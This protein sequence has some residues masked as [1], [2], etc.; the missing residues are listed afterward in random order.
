MSIVFLL[1]CGHWTPREI[2]VWARNWWSTILRAR[3]FLNRSRTVL[4][5]VSNW[6]VFLL[7]KCVS[8][9]RPIKSQMHF[10]Y[11]HM[12]AAVTS[13]GNLQ[14]LIG[15]GMNAWTIIKMNLDLTL[16]NESFCFHAV[17]DCIAFAC[18]RE[19]HCLHGRSLK[20][21]SCTLRA[22]A[23][24]GTL[25]FNYRIIYRD[26]RCGRNDHVC[27]KVFACILLCEIANRQK[28]QFE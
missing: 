2:F 28:P 21:I 22:V 8:F 5:M 14:L 1:F 10:V 12:T 25:H 18:V 3:V 20:R 4:K 13:K 16:C 19:V 23:A 27:A 7:E 24:I 26:I 11:G 6:L 15:F 9:V 17:V